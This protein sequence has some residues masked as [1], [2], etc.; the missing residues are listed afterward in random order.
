MSQPKHESFN[1]FISPTRNTLWALAMNKPKI[2]QSSSHT[3]VSHNATNF[4]WIRRFQVK[5]YLQKAIKPTKML[6]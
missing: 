1:I 5:L 3:E 4:Y 2:T 6:Q